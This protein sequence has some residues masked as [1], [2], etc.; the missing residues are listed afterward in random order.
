MI[1]FDPKTRNLLLEQG[2]RGVFLEGNILKL[3]S[4]SNDPEFDKYLEECI[5]RD[6]DTRRKRLDITKKVQIQNKELVS[7]KEHNEKLNE[8]LQEALLKAEKAMKSAQSDLDILQRRTQYELMGSIVKVSLWVICG[9]G[10]IT[11]VLYGVSLIQN[12]ENRVVE[13]TWSNMLSILLTNSF[14]IIGTVMGIKYAS[15][16]KEKKCPKA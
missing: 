1:E 8:E 2:K 14:S 11:T 16:K 10:L 15:E 12:I 13:S 9:C 3:I 5:V 6:N 4:K 7:W